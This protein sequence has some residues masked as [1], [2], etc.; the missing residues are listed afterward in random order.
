MGLQSSSCR[1]RWAARGSKAPGPQPPPEAWQQCLFCMSLDSTTLVTVQMAS[2]AVEE[3][4]GVADLETVPLGPVQ[5][6]RCKPPSPNPGP[7]EVGRWVGVLGRGE[8]PHGSYGLAPV[9]YR[10]GF[11]HEDGRRLT[12]R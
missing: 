11:A 10:R 5:G 9:T 6:T 7:A 8:A 4:G 3:L 2:R 12:S 1:T